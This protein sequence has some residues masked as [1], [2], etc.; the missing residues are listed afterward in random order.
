MELI[1]HGLSFYKPDERV[2][3]RNWVTFILE[4]AESKVMRQGIAAM[5]PH[6]SG[7]RLWVHDG[8][9]VR[10]EEAIPYFLEGA[11]IAIADL[12]DASHRL[13]GGDIPL[14]ILE[15]VSKAFEV[16]S[17]AK[18]F[19]N[20]MDQLHQQGITCGHPFVPKPR[21]KIVT[22][23]AKASDILEVVQHPDARWSG[24]STHS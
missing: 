21:S 23:Q 15:D 18:A 13:L 9:Y 16:T 5:I 24:V 6:C 17:T 19:Q 8:I 7:S 14:R 20:A 12:L 4:A 22:S 2:T 1:R 3:S 10:R 11:R